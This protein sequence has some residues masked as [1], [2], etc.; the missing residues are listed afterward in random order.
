MRITTVATIPD[1]LAKAWLQHLR[2]FD[3]ANPGCH[4]N[5]VASASDFSTEAIVEVLDGIEPPLPM[6]KVIRRG[7]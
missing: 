2:D 1:E 6:K 7:Q 5:I 4:F 3:V